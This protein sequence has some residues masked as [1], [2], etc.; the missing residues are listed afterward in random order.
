MPGL[1]DISPAISPQTPVWPGDT[2]VTFSRTWDMDGGAPVN[3]SKT[4]MSTHT[5]AHADAPLHYK[6]DGADIA[7]VSLE[8][9]IGPATVIH[10][11]GAAPRVELSQL[12]AGL[13]DAGLTA[14]DPRLLIRTYPKAPQAR[15][16]PDFAAV[17]P[18]L[19]DWFADQGG[20]LIGIDTPSLDPQDSK[21]MEAHKRVAAHD[22]RVLEGLVL[23]AVP[24]GRYELIAPPL[25][26]AG[27]DAAPVR[28]VLR[29][30]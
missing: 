26:L 11:L 9:Y 14:P 12:H 2:P 27:L 4:V 24:P 28:A 1:I 3:V 21:T 25:K 19:I 20:V 16:D 22:M 30:I 8:A 17:A 18:E 7:A 5:G 23:D 10:A 6:A 15:W 29:E 13:S